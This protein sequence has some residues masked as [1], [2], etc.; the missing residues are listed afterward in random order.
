MLHLNLISAVDVSI[1][2][3]CEKT[4]LRELMSEVSLFAKKAEPDMTAV[5]FNHRFRYRTGKVDRGHIE[6]F[7]KLWNLRPNDKT[8]D[9]ISRIPRL[10][11]P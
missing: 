3:W 9:Q 6:M 5:N 11:V 2:N 8:N 7:T 1:V 4:V 10:I